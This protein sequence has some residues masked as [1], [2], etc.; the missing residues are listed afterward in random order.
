MRAS[1]GLYPSLGSNF[2]NLQ[3]LADAGCMTPRHAQDCLRGRK[4]FTD[5]QKVA[6]QNYVAMKNK[7]DMATADDFD[8]T[9]RIK[10]A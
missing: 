3:E 7:K 6:I 10:G 5:Q 8:L 4:Q 1:C 2:K 9:Y